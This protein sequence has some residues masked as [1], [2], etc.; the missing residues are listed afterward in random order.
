[1]TLCFCKHEKKYMTNRNREMSGE[2]LAR[3]FVNIHNKINPDDI[4]PHR[5]EDFAFFLWTK[6]G[7]IGYAIMSFLNS[8]IR[9]E[10]EEEFAQDFEK[11]GL[12]L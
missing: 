5:D 8:E 9:Y 7:S 4:F 12:W 11:N 10:Y 3:Q 2:E 6:N 1:M